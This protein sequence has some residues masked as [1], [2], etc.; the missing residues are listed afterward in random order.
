MEGSAKDDVADG[1][2]KIAFGGVN[3]AVKLLFYE[4]AGSCR[5][6][7]LDLFCVSEIRRIKGGGMEI[8]FYD[9][10]QALDRLR[11]MADTDS[12]GSDFLQALE[13]GAAALA[14]SGEAEPCS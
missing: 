12:G 4:D 3:D 1:Y 8:T 5:V 13:R 10:L 9:R 6:K 14:R 7:N 2:R 11:E